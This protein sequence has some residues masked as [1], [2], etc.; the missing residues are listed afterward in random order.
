MNQPCNSNENNY[1][2]FKN[3]LNHLLRIAKRMY[4][5]KQLERVKTNTKN[6]WKILNEVINRKKAIKRLPTDFIVNNR[7]ISNPVE[8]ADHFCEYFTNIGPNLTNNIDNSSC[9]YKSYLTDDMVNS[10]F[11]DLVT[12]TEVKEI[13]DGLR[14]GIASG[15]DEIP[16]WLVKG[17]SELISS[18]LKHV[19]NIS[20]NSGIVPDQTKIAR[21]LP[22]FKSGDNRVFSN[23]RP[24]SVLPIFSKVFEKV[25]YNRL[26]DYFNKSGILFQNQFGFRKGHSTSLA[27]HHLY[28]KITAAIDQRKF[29]V[30]IFLDLSKA[31][32]TVNHSILLDKLEHYGVRGLVLEWIKSYFTNRQQYVEYNG[33]CS[34]KKLY[35]AVFLKD[36]F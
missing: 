32:D 20:I 14:C 28:D 34:Q 31:F 30:G 24:V 12:D 35:N 33:T 18:P 1:K 3:K 36:Q 10:V 16:M 29:T 19:I 26:F 13:I 11:F 9:C 8:I 22:L 15:Y 6:T 7:N 5:E 2:T 17:S 25:V 23:Y 27:L 21:I 4:Y